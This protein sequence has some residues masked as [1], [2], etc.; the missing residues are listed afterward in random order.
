M[1]GLKKGQGT[2]KSHKKTLRGFFLLSNK[3]KPQVFTHWPDKH[4][5]FWQ[6]PVLWGSTKILE[7]SRKSTSSDPPSVREISCHP[8]PRWSQSTTETLTVFLQHC[9]TMDPSR[10]WLH[11]L[12]PHAWRR[13]EASRP[14]TSSAVSPG[15]GASRIADF[16]WSYG[17]ELFLFSVLLHFLYFFVFSKILHLGMYFKRFTYSNKNVEELKA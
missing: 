14:T 2:S 15:L 4:K 3:T 1:L 6:S 5:E 7:S 13:R 12:R 11:V 17:G 16:T 9:P 8:H 10:R